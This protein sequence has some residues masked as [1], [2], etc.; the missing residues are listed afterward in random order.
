MGVFSQP[1]NR[2]LFGDNLQWLRDVNIFPD[3]SVEFAP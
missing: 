3:A 2:L 1:M